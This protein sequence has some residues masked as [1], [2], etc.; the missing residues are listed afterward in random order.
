[1]E[2]LPAWIRPYIGI[3]FVDRGR[4]RAGCDCWGLVRMVYR[5]RLGISL[6]D[7]GPEYGS[8]D[9]REGVAQVIKDALGPGGPGWQL[10]SDAPM[11]PLDIVLLRVRGAPWHV[12]VVV[13]PRQAQILHVMRGTR[14]CVERLHGASWLRRIAGRYR[15]DGRAGVV[16]A[17]RET[18]FGRK[19]DESVPA[20][21]TLVQVLAAAGLEASPMLRVFIG[22][23]EVPADRWQHVRPL[24]GRLVTVAA[25][26]AFGGGGGD[27]GKTALRIIATIALIAGAAYATP[28]LAAGALG[29]V[30]AAVVVGAATIGAGLA[31]TALAPPSKTKLTDDTSSPTISGARN[32]MRPYQRVIDVAGFHRLV[33]P[34]AAAPYTE[35]TG[36]A[37][38]LRLLFDCGYGPKEISEIR[39]GETSI[40]DYEGVEVET[41]PGNADDD[42]CRLFPGTVFEE[43]LSVLL[44]QTAA[45]T[46]RTTSPGVD[47]I[48]VDV[49]FPSGLA[50]STSDGSREPYAVG[51]DVEYSVAGSGVWQRVNGGGAGSTGSPVDARQLDILFRTPEVSRSGGGVHTGVVAWGLGF[52][53]TKPGYLPGANFSWVVEGWFRD[54]DCPENGGNYTFGIDGSDAMDLEIDGRLVASW[55]GGHSPVGGDAAP[56]DFTAHASAPVF[57][58]RGWHRIKLRVECRSTTGAVAVGWITPAAGVWATM[59][60]TGGGGGWRLQASNDSGAGLL[61]TWYDTTVYTSTI[62]VEAERTDPFQ[63]TLAWAVPRGQYDVRLHRITAD[64]ADTRLLDDV[65]WT[66]LRG[67]RA[68][69]PVRMPGRAKIALRIRATD[70]LNGVIDNLSCMVREVIPDWDA[71]SG[72]WISRATNNP[73]SVYR[74]RLQGPSVARPLADARID[75]E[76][77]QTWHEACTAEGWAFNAVFDFEGTVYERLTDIAAAGRASVGYRDGKVSVVRDRPQTVPVQLITP[78]NSFGF[79]GRKV[80]QRIPHALRVSFLNEDIGYQLDERIVLNDGY[81]LDGLDAFGNPAPAL[82]EP[83]EYETLEIFGVTDP[84]VIWRHGRFHLATAKLRPEIVDIGM[85]F[86]H[87][88]C[89]RGDMV[90]FQHYAWGETSSAA[91]R[92]RGLTLDT[93]GNLARVR[94][95]ETIVMDAGVDYGIRV[96]LADGTLWTRALVTIEGE[97]TILHL[98]SPASTGEPWPEEGDLAVVGI[99]T[100]EARE[101]IVQ[102]I[103]PDA[104]LG[105]R[106]TLVDHAPAIHQADTGPI[107]DWES[108]ITRGPAWEDGPDAPVIEMIRSDDWVMVR[109]GDGSF[110]PRMV[111]TLRRPSSNRPTPID[112]DVGLRPTVGGGVGPALPYRYRRFPLLDN[113]VIVDQVEVGQSYDIRLRVVTRIGQASAW[114]YAVHVVQGNVLPPPDVASFSVAQLPDGTRRYSWDLGAIPPDIDGVLIRYYGRTD[115]PDWSAMTPLHTEVMDAASP[116][117][118]NLPEPGSWTFGIKMIDTAGNESVNALFVDAV[119]TSTARAELIRSEDAQALGWPGTLT[120]CIRIMG[121]FG[122]ELEAID[123]TTWDGLAAIGSPTWADWNRWNMQPRSPIVYEHTMDIGAVVNASP[124]IGF[125]VSG[126]VVVEFFWSDDGIAY[127]GPLSR[128]DAIV[129]NFNARY[130]RVRLTVTANPSGGFTVPR[131]ES[132][133]IQARG[134]AVEAFLDNVSTAALAPGYRLGVGDF[135]VPLEPE[136][137]GVISHVNLTFNGSGAGFTYELVDRVVSPG[138]RL[139]IYGPDDLPADAIVDVYV[140]GFG[141]VPPEDLGAVSGAMFASADVSALIAAV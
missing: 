131:I 137:F 43:Q 37:Q 67:V 60:A 5:D 136:A 120:D 54:V 39:I 57:L 98:A 77:L 13:D 59:P 18:P 138:P 85:D 97:S 110:A 52:P 69:D 79:R 40:D 115:T 28:I 122:L 93:G 105:A 24:P 130:Y 32:E 56:P 6:E 72:Q 63:R 113:N 139:R 21:G 34:F 82:P 140:R 129:R 22:H 19:V 135:R 61:Y 106:L 126:D 17:G 95:D 58:R 66:A 38:Y 64:S 80:F 81:Q 100:Q 111:I 118:L 29:E 10:V 125:G 68:E 20:G 25:A 53:E 87:L 92:V 70:Q 26:P 46:V 23:V 76:E 108:G 84:G 16:V 107:P 83:T 123:D 27:G 2:V 48:S 30:G 4:T 65:Y 109:Q 47:E 90:L 3:E 15:L 101:M 7:L 114:V 44:E 112:A 89:T 73:A 103:E 86:E 8:A 12:G 33:P 9:D 45:A 99:L 141:G 127:D 36:D 41:R 49:T 88:V 117:E 119:L 124:D 102:R 74:A 1:M 14:A 121:R 51:V 62:G 96:R 104:D 132:L 94:V 31:L 35:S 134:E 91:T 75:L 55:Y 50:R 133:I 116:Q 42:P 71:A 128:E 78:R 11:E